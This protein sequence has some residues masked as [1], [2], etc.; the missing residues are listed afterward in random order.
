M[1]LSITRAPVADAGPNGSTCQ[2]MPYTVSGASAQYATSVFWTHNGMGT[3]SGETTL[4]PTYMPAVYETG[5]V[6]LTLTAFGNAPCGT[7]TDF[8]SLNVIPKPTAYAGPDGSTCQGTPFTVTLATATSYSGILWTS[9]G[10][11][12]LTNENSLTPT[13]LPAA[14]ESGPVILSMSVYGY[15]PC[16]S[17]GDAM[18]L[19]ITP[20]A[21]VNAGPDL[22]TCGISPVSLSNSSATNYTTLT[23]RTSG[24]GVFSDASA[25]HPFYTP[26]Q[27]DTLD[28][29]VVLT[30]HASAGPNCAEVTD[31]MILTISKTAMANAG[32]D[33]STCLGTPFVITNAT[34][35][36]YT[37]IL[38]TT[39]GLGTLT[40]ETTI[41]P[42]YTPA[43]GESGVVTLTLTVLSLSQCPPA[44]DQMKLTISQSSS[45][46][47]GP[48]ATI[49][50]DNS[51]TIS[52]SGA[53]SYQEIT[54]TTAGSGTFNDSHLLH[55]VYTP[56]TGDILNGFVKLTMHVVPIYPCPET[57]SYMTLIISRKA[58]AIAGA[59][60]MTCPGIPFRVT[61]ASAQN[62]SSIS[63]SSDGLGSLTD[64]TTLTPTYIPANGETGN[65]TLTLSVLGTEGCI[66]SAQTDQMILSIRPPV[67][68]NAGPDQ[69]IPLNSATFLSGSASGGTGPYVFSWEPATLLLGS[70]SDHPETVRLNT[71]VTFTLTVTDMTTGCRAADTVTIFMKKDVIPI[72]AV[73]DYDTT[74]V[75]VPIRM[76]ILRND[77]YSK[78]KEVRVTLCGGPRHGLALVNSDN[79]IQFTPDRDFAGNDSMCYILCYNAYS[80]VCDTAMV[81]IYI[82]PNSAANLVVIYNVITPN[83]DGMNDGWIIDGIEKFPD[84]SVKLFNRWGDEINSFEHYDN[85][86][87]VWKGENSKGEKLPDGTYF[88][89]LTIKDGGSRSGWVMIR[90]TSR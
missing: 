36:N 53:V 57:S 80:S 37:S 63:W 30:L 51:Y 74:A 27:S 12:T 21:T 76:N 88:Y 59:D 9:N 14:N 84:N 28:G 15:T 5:V 22:T 17:T 26:S 49:C 45:A 61:G 20:N 90:G 10:L 78:D 72:V 3:L 41:N 11:G 6:T 16:G 58:I 81:Y 33:A 7:S 24:T 38:W 47:A 13:Y 86:S 40:G 35:Q 71:D 44:I 89:I 68:V 82:S 65:I 43:T 55:P 75:N 85:H 34:A 70:A 79:S 4:T 23:W 46:Y 1:T 56:G 62:F 32:P 69:T 31:F 66:S 18:T 67:L 52:G 25:L 19:S 73:N 50:E 48:D 42:V 8:M 60:A 77:I 29:S 2:G 64:N 87:I 83:G 54:W 39:N